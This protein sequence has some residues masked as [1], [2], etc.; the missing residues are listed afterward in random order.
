MVVVVVVVVLEG[1]IHHAESDE[2]A[3]KTELNRDTN[4]SSL[5]RVEG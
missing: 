1:V 2:N 3:I 5:I 4:R